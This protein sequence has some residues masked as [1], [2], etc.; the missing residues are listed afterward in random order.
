[1]DASDYEVQDLAF[2]KRCTIERLGN[3][4]VHL[5]QEES[6]WLIENNTSTINQLSSESTDTN[7][8]EY[9]SVK[10]L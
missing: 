2:V 3:F 5:L 4:V 1:M 8:E 7:K 9:W 10:V 6:S